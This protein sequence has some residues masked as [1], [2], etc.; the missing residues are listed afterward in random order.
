MRTSGE[1]KQA[2]PTTRHRHRERQQR[3]TSLKLR[4]RQT[5]I[6][7]KFHDYTIILER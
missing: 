2:S 7:P 4:E 1:S 5:L 6:S 3:V